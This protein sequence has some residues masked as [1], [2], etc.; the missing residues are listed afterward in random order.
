MGEGV[1]E[2]CDR[3]SCLNTASNTRCW[4]CGS[5]IERTKTGTVNKI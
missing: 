3:C 4:N 2:R 1:L 5:K